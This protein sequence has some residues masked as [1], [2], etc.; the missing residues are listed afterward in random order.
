MYLNLKINLL[1][2]WAW[3]P[4]P[5]AVLLCSG[6]CVLVSWACFCACGCVE[7]VGDVKWWW[8]LMIQVPGKTCQTHGTGC[9]FW[10]SMLWQTQTHTHATHTQLPMQV[11]KPVMGTMLDM[12]GRGE[13]LLATSKQV[14]DMTGRGWPHWNRCLMWQGGVK[15]PPCH[16]VVSTKVCKVSYYYNSI[17]LK[18][19]PIVGDGHNGPSPALVVSPCLCCAMSCCSVVAVLWRL[20]SMVSNGGGLWCDANVMVWCVIHGYPCVVPIP[21]ST[22]TGFMQVWV[23]VRVKLPVGYLWQTLGMVN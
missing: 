3:Q 4:I 13:P 1:W 17:F 14:L 23:Q 5:T 10:M 22:G 11:C 16:V 12:M 19:A 8:H 15:N 2:G 7:V 18:N 20:L 21:M 9:G 6:A